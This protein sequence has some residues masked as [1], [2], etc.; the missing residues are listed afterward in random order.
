M[1]ERQRDAAP[2]RQARRPRRKKSRAP[3]A[4]LLVLLLAGGIYG[5]HTLADYTGAFQSSRE[6]TVSI[7][8]GSSGREIAA[9]LR[10][11]GVISHPT[12]FYAYARFSG[13]GGGFKAGEY[14][15]RSDMSYSEIAGLLVKGTLRED[16]A[17]VTFPEGLTLREIAELLEQNGVC[18]AA[19]FLDYLDTADL[20]RYDFVAELPQ[21]D[22][23]RRLEGYIFPDT[24]Q[25]YLGEDVSNVAT[26]FLDRFEQ[27]VDDEIRERADELGMSID[28]VVTLAS[29]IQAECSFPSEM[30]AV[31]GVFH[32]RL[33]NP[34][35][36]PKLQ[37]DVTIFYIRDEILPVA[38]SSREDFY[39]QLYNTYIH[40]GLPVGPICCPGEDAIQ[41][42]LYPEE[43]DYYYFITDKDGN[44]MYAET[45]GQHNANISEAGI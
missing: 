42:A 6:V 16:V 30:P 17:T 1:N 15:L 45:L 5:G 24:Y 40:N 38:G 37:S 23:F 4:V 32:N 36:Y 41:A 33:N 43:N 12:V 9:L 11:S 31:S 34:A 2:N 39:D 8:D 3:L 21:D 19:E 13:Q 22:R 28:E 35:E 20:D 44:F 14:T 25:F 7:P 10:E 18:P 26:R 29:V 27:V